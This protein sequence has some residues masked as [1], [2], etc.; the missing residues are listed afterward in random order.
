VTGNNKYFAL[1][2][3]RARELG[4]SRQDVINLS[5]PG[6]RHLRGLDLT[7]RHMRE[8]GESGA[9]TLLFRP[10]QPSAAGRAYISA[11]ESIGVPDAYKCRVRDP[12]WRVPLVE[13]AD[14]LLTYMNADTPRVTTNRA[15][16]HHLNSVHGIYLAENL[17]G[18]GRDLLPLATLN[19]VTVLGAEI[20]G[21]A[22]GGGMLKI[23]PREADHLPVPSS[24]VVEAVADDLRRARRHVADHL[25]DG[26][27]VEAIAL[28]DAIVLVGALGV[29]P[30]E[31]RSLRH[32]RRALAARRAA[33]GAS[34]RD[35]R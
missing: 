32:A 21:R 5:P 7:D 4:L 2:P 8:L 23:E 11:G 34:E 25:K 19:S 24:R 13:P 1:S 29:N 3:A 30:R 10:A 18:L 15:R 22:Y 6:S 35:R 33:R 26:N 17:T 14:L 20:V 12:W 31:L 16:V 27:L 9:A 28:V